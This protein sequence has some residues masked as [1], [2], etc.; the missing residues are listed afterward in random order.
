MIMVNKIIYMTILNVQV[1]LEKEVY[2][3]RCEEL[4]KEVQSLRNEVKWL[5]HT[6]EENKRVDIH[7]GKGT[8]RC[9]S[10]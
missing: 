4:M 8:Y 6:I 5:S 10:S 3:N 7:R 1:K 2:K 9:R